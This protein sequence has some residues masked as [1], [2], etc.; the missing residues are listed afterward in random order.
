[1]ANNIELGNSTAVG[2]Y[3]FIARTE[4]QDIDMFYGSQ[5]G[6]YKP[7]FHQSFALSGSNPVMYGITQNCKADAF[8]LTVSGSPMR[9]CLSSGASASPANG[10]YFYDGGTYIIPLPAGQKMSDVS[11]FRINGVLSEVNITG[12]N[13]GGNSGSS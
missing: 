5:L 7:I 12:L 6:G 10:A 13:L 1:M 11:F 2:T 3:K 9:M 4:L 8:L